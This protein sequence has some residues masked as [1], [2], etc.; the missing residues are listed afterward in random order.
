MGFPL[1]GGGGGGGG[2]RRGGGGGGGGGGE[3]SIP[4]NSRR[5][6]AAQYFKFSYYGFIQLE[7]IDKYVHTPP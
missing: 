5:R 1:G 6:C 3:G 7:P 4:R 2:S